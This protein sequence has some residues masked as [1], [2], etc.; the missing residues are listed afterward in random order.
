MALRIKTRQETDYFCTALYDL[1]FCALL[2]YCIDQNIY[3]NREMTCHAL[4]HLTS[5][6]ANRS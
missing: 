4:L 2:L 3:T 1:R 6:S 5:L